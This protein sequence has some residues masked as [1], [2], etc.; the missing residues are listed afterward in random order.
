V[1]GGALG[2]ET[3]VTGEGLGTTAGGVGGGAGRGVTSGGRGGI[4]TN[5]PGR[6][7]WGARRIAGSF[8]KRSAWPHARQIR[9]PIDSSPR[10]RIDN[11]PP[12]IEPV[13]S[14]FTQTNSVAPQLLQ[15]GGTGNTLRTEQAPIPYKT[16]RPRAL[17]P[18][19][20]HGDGL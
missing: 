8:R 5:S 2:A 15:T 4:G 1:G 7:V 18:A 17:V 6:H 14:S 9:V 16:V 3:G 12:P 20:A 19:R 10:E 11:V 13:L